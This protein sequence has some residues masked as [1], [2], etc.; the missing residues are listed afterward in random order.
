MKSPSLHLH[1]QA[2]DRPQEGI[3]SDTVAFLLLQ[4]T[5]STRHQ[6]GTDR[7][8]VTLTSVPFLQFDPELQWHESAPLG[9]SLISAVDSALPWS[10]KRN[11][12]VVC[13]AVSLSSIVHTAFFVVFF[14]NCAAGSLEQHK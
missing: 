1:S 4:E 5:A 10:H 12:V 3:I 8:E 9:A 14:S 7:E 6:C 11:R 13:A 2:P